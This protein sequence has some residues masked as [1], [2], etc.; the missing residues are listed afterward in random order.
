MQSR[1]FNIIRVLLFSTLFLPVITLGNEKDD[2]ADRLFHFANGLYKRELYKLAISQ[3]QKF[4]SQYPDNPNTGEAVFLLGESYFKFENLTEA[5]NTFNK[6]VKGHPDGKTVG[7][8]SFRIGYIEFSEANHAAAIESLNKALSFNP[9]DAALVQINYYL[10]K[11]YFEI[12]NFKEAITHLKEVAGEGSVQLRPHALFAMA[13]AFEKINDYTNTLETFYQLIGEFPNHELIPITLFRVGE[14][15]FTLERYEDAASGLR[16]LL[17]LQHEE[18][19]EVA[20]H[21]LAWCYYLLKDTKQLSALVDEFLISFPDSKYKG[22]MRFFKAEIIFEKGDSNAALENYLKAIERGGTGDFI[23]QSYYKLGL[24][25]EKLEGYPKAIEY[26]NTLIKDYPSHTLS[27]AAII[28]TARIYEKGQDNP[29]EALARYQ[30]YLTTIPNGQYTELATFRSAICQFTM[31]KYDDMAGTFEQFIMNFSTSLWVAEAMYYVGWN[32]ER[33]KDY[34][35][36]ITY[37]ERMLESGPEESTHPSSSGTDDVEETPHLDKLRD[38][39]R[40]RLALCYY[41]AKRHPEAAEGFYEILTQT[42]DPSEQKI[43]EEVLLWLGEY[44]SDEKNDYEKAITVYKRLFDESPA[45]RWAERCL[46]RLG[47]WHGRLGEWKESIL[48]YERMLKDFPKSELAAFARLGTAESYE[49]LKEFP[50]ALKLYE[51]LA[52]GGT[53]LVSARASLG[54]GNIFAVKGNYEEAILSYMYVAILFDNAE[55]CSKALLASSNCWLTMGDTKQSNA[56]LKE[57]LDR[58]PDG[59]YSS[60]AKEKL[61]DSE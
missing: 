7:T 50:V 29:S 59:P 19:T 1:L 51:S 37:Y 10:G 27:E 30:T 46:Y 42:T 43:P 58:Y 39:T 22:E 60:E 21:R 35:K 23:A 8:A 41:N 44:F 17:A 2:P 48:S 4:L 32:L 5:K 20:Q 36:A 47:E 13:T 40:F 38:D 9:E 31:K 24:I 3:Y 28:Q 54:I 52:K 61:K 55:I 45:S 33:K 34:E 16:G 49:N 57:L 25:Y 56:S 14:L 26:F 11:S 6:Y 53:T 12:D 18:L 15:L